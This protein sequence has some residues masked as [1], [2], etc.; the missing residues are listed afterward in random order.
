MT[1]A[2][3]HHSYRRSSPL[4]TPA[5]THGAQS[6]LPHQWAWMHGRCESDSQPLA[7][8]SQL[9]AYHGPRTDAGTHPPRAR[10]TK[11]A[12]PLR[13]C[14][15][16][17]FSTTSLCCSHARRYHIR[18]GPH[19]MLRFKRSS[20]RTPATVTRAVAV[21]A[22]CT[23]PARC[24]RSRCRRRSAR[25]RTRAGPKS[26]RAAWVPGLDWEKAI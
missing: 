2:L 26:G 17:S 22:P 24:R 3:S 1:G 21:A 6:R 15:T 12:T 19:R 25:L 16:T 23:A 18:S 10:I 11:N 4:Q 5:G 8:T 13:R 20:V 7:F 9:R 14:T